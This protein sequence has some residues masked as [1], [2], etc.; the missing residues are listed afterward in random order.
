MVH[1]ASDAVQAQ[2]DQANQVAE[3]A[4]KTLEE[5]SVLTFIDSVG[6][7]VIVIGINHAVKETGNKNTIRKVKHKK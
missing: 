7:L 1:L 6:S 2:Q 5:E 4:D 3:K